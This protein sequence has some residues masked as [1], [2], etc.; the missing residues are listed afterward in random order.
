MKNRKLNQL[1]VAGMIS[2]AMMT[3]GIS[4][5]AADF[6]DDTS[7]VEEQSVDAAEEEAPDVEDG[8]EFQ[9]DAAEASSAVAVSSANFPDAKF[10]QYIL[11]NIDTDKDKMLSAAE[12]KAA[13]T[14]DVSGLGISNLKGIESFTYATDL[15]AANNKLTSVN[16][17]KNTKVAYLNLSNNSLAGTLDLSKCTN[18]R[19]VKYGSNKLTK[20][21]MPSK[22]YLKNLDFVDASSNKFTTQ[23][24][25]GLNI[26]DTDYVKN[27]SEVNVSNNAITSFNCAGFQG[28][29]D[30]RNN[31]ITNLKLENSKEGSQVV[32]LYLDGNSLSKTPSIDFTP[33]WI[34]VPQQ[35]SCD[36]GVSSKVKMLKATA[37][38]TSATW[39]QIV[40]N[41]GSSTDDAS[42]KLEKKTG[43]GTYET[44][45]T[46]DNGDLA[47]AEFGE[48]YT[49]NVISTGTAYTYRVTATVQVKDA[50]KNLRSWSNSAEVKATATGT[51]PAISVKSTK[52]GVATVSW[53]AVAGADGYDVYCGSS[54]KSQKGTVVKGTTKLTANRTKLTSGKTYYF[55]ARAYKMVGSSKVYT[56]YS[57]VKSVKVK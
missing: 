41:V 30:L 38:I 4:V 43:N 44:V 1:L 35:F 47:D 29:L 17:T 51:K 12:I 3:S 23:A 10:R 6:S 24:N 39:D 52:K 7:T 40:V 32:S 13:K 27:L 53:K 16:I 36:A 25:A 19:V 46:W 20:V 22:K 14:I 8:S 9:S 15:F 21:V 42:Y 2:A 28:I 31:K 33:E 18:L 55:R 48:D 5:Q 54:R 11:D 45:K 37:S 49:D 56:G 26:G 34:A 57:T 50:N